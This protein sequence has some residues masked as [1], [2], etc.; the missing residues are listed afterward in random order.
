MKNSSGTV[1]NDLREFSLIVIILLENSLQ[2]EFNVTLEFIS[3]S[4]YYH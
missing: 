3:S 1:P 2:I 4:T